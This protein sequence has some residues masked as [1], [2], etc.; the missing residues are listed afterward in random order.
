[1]NTVAVR[2]GYDRDKFN[3]RTQILHNI[4]GMENTLDRAVVL[5]C[6]DQKNIFI[7]SRKTNDI[8]NLNPTFQTS[9]L[10]ELFKSSGGEYSVYAVN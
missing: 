8:P 2:N 1:M 5:N 10:Q 7:V 3:Y 6:L 9:G 4:Y